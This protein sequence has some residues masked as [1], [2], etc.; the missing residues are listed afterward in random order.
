[1]C[2]MTIFF[3]IVILNLKLGLSYNVKGKGSF[4]YKLGRIGK[5]F[6]I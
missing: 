1:M 4:Q 5:G 6:I 3:V 2:A